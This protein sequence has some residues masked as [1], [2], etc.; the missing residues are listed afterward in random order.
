MRTFSTPMMQQY[1]KNKKQYADC[2]LFFRLGDFYELFLDDALLGAKLLGITLTKRPRGKDG[3]IPM[4]GVPYHAANTYISKLIK[5]GHKIALCEQVSAPNKKSIVERAVVRIITPGTVLDD[6]SL[7]GSSHNF[8]MSVAFHPKTVGIAVADISTGL[9]KIT[10]FERTN[11][12]AQLVERELLRFSPSECIVSNNT[13]D[14]PELLGIVLQ[15]GTSISPFE[16]WKKDKKA[17]KL[18]SDHFGSASLSTLV[19]KEKSAVFEAM[20]SLLA[21][22]EHTQK[23]T[24]EHFSSPEWYSASD[25]LVLDASTIRNLELFSTIRDAEKTG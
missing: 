12:L 18:L 2:L 6:D 3:D 10:E 15:T 17:F 14:D 20:A 13:Y 4:A 7:V 11:A 25:S 8:L 21:Y 23:Q 9:L 5:L 22:I 1:I 19:V 16:D 24:V